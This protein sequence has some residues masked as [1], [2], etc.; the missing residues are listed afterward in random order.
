MK[1]KFIKFGRRNSGK[2][3][4]E[5][6]PLKIRKVKSKYSHFVNITFD[7]IKEKK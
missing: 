5:S 6:D 7:E 4:M 2:I 3:M 1:F